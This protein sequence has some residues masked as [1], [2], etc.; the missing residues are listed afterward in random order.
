MRDIIILLDIPIMSL[1]FKAKRYVVKGYLACFFFF[2]GI[3]QPKKYEYHWLR[4]SGFFGLSKIEFYQN[5]VASFLQN[6]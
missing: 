1:Y 3:L 4:T 2:K 6:D 5:V